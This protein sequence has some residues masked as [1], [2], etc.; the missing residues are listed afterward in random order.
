[1]FFVYVD[2][3]IHHE[4]LEAF[5]PLMRANAKAS[6]ET[7]EG[8]HQFDVIEVTDAKGQ[9]MLYELYDDRAAFDS[10]LKSNHF[11]EFD[12]KVARM[13]AH[14]AVRTGVVVA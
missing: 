3:T 7:E 8:C 11:Q 5:L 9:F 13:I 4:D 12:A 6:L 1:M 2:L 14:K 10:H